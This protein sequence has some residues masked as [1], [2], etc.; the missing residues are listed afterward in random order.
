MV[1]FSGSHECLPKTSAIVTASVVLPVASRHSSWTTP[2]YELSG[3]LSS[4]F[5]SRLTS[6]LPGVTRNAGPVIEQGLSASF[7]DLVNNSD[8]LPL[9]GFLV[10]IETPEVAFQS[11]L[12]FGTSKSSLKGTDWINTGRSAS[13]RISAR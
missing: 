2:S 8:P 3:E 7:T 6:H 12:S 11:S 10:S 4:D 5:H 9:I 1:F 13:A